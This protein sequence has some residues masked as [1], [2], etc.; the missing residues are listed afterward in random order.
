MDENHMLDFLSQNTKEPFFMRS[1]GAEA[2]IHPRKAK[3]SKAS[4]ALS[5]TP[6]S[7]SGGCGFL[8]T[9]HTSRPFYQGRKKRL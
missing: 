9:K 6:L 3:Q 2:H 8:V 4:H 1:P 7:Q 5:K